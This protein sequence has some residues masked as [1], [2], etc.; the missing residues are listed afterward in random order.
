[1]IPVNLLQFQLSKSFF[2][3]GTTLKLFDPYVR[4]IYANGQKIDSET[5]LTTT[6]NSSE[7]AVFLTDHDLF[8]TPDTLR[9]IESSSVQVSID[10][11]NKFPKAPAGKVYLGIGK[12]HYLN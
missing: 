8:K 4:D 7:C 11:R 3:E 9:Q 2:E 12:P 6:S 10:G 5:N 1:M